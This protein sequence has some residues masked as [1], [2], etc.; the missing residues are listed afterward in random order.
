MEG[1]QIT[2]RMGPRTTLFGRGTLIPRRGLGGRGRRSPY[3]EEKGRQKNPLGVRS[4][5]DLPARGPARV[6]TGIAPGWN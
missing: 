1:V 6:A 3:S 4:Y 2:G 5:T